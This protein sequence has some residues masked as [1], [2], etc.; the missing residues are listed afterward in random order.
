MMFS[1][2]G[3]G[4]NTG[5]SGQQW[6]FYIKILVFKHQQIIQSFTCN[7][8]IFQLQVVHVAV[9]SIEQNGCSVK[10]FRS[11]KQIRLHTLSIYENSSV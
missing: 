1:A 2:Y 6:V 5:I 11:A 9:V 10:E 8:S 4:Q 3:E 7:T